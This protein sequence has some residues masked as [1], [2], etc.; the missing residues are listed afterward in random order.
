[1]ATW[2]VPTLHPAAL[3]RDQTMTLAVLSD[4][5]KARRIHADGGPT[6][7]PACYRAGQPMPHYAIFPTAQCVIDWLAAHKGH[8]LSLD[9]ESTYFDQI[10]CLGIWSVDTALEDEGICVPFFSRGGVKYWNTLDEL[11]VKEA[12]FSMLADAT[13]PKVGQNFVGFDVPMMRKVWGVETRGVIGDTMVAHWSVMPELLHGL[14]FLSSIFTDLS[15]YKVEVHSN[16]T[17]KDDTDKWQAVQDYDDRNLREYCLLD[18][19][20]TALAWIALV[21]MMA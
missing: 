15:P 21:R 17:E 6:L 2:I 14:A 16:E 8:T 18:T 3:V 7:I 5:E 9:I 11:R 10:M 13:W 12:V 20:A 4:L 19:F 1:M